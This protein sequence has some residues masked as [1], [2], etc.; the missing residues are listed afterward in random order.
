MCCC[1]IILIGVLPLA[2]A[3]Q[4]DGQSPPSPRRQAVPFDAMEITDAF[5]SSRLST[6]RLQAIPH[7]LDIDDVKI[8]VNGRVVSFGRLH[9]GYVRLSRLWQAG[10]QIEIELPMRVIRVACDPRAACNAGRIALQ[11]G[12]IVYCVEAVDHGG[13]VRDLHLQPDAKL[14]PEHRPNLLGGVTV[15]RGTALDIDNDS[16]GYRE[17]PLLTVPY[18]VWGNRDIG[19][20]DVWLQVSKEKT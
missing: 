10:D 2:I 15:L 17:V 16:G 4:S 6:N 9:R 18:A 1:D 13:R 11:R 19:E 3:G 8:R 14:V 20:M 7:V 12:P 5:W